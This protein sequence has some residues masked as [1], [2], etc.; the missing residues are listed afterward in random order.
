MNDEDKN[1]NSNKDEHKP[2]D[3]IGLNMSGHI[4]IKDKETGE[5]IVTEPWH[6]RSNYNELISK[7]ESNYKSNCRENL[8]D[9]VPLFTDQSLDIGITEYLIKRSKLF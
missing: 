7:L 6:I 9:Y 8:I 5:E 4:L 3:Q 1:M 2:D